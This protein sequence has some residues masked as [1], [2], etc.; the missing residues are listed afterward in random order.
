MTVRLGGLTDISLFAWKCTPINFSPLQFELHTGD[1]LA[2]NSS[3]FL[4]AK[5]NTCRNQVLNITNNNN[6]NTSMN[7]T[8]IRQQVL[9]DSPEIK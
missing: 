8:K 4:L 9:W 6:N 3:S 7:V 5:E 2:F 1:P